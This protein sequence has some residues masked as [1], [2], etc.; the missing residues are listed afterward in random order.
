MLP[1]T[2]NAPHKKK[3]KKKKKKKNS[4]KSTSKNFQTVLWKPHYTILSKNCFE[5]NELMP[6]RKPNTHFKRNYFFHFKIMHDQLFKN[7]IL[8]KIAIKYYSQI[9]YS[10]NTKYH[11]KRCLLQSSI[12]VLLPLPTPRPAKCTRKTMYRFK[13]FTPMVSNK[14]PT[15]SV[16]I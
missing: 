2:E 13:N 10:S 4:E 16:I 5:K 8:P 9:H 12:K 3:K 15:N 1:I 7:T 11:A 6:S 14:P